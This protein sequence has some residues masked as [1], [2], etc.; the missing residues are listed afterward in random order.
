MPLLWRYWT[1]KFSIVG[2]ILLSGLYVPIQVQAADY[3]TR[4]QA[5]ATLN[6]QHLKQ[7]GSSGNCIDTLLDLANLEL[8][9]RYDQLMNRYQQPVAGSRT[10]TDAVDQQLLSAQYQWLQFRNQQCLFEAQASML[11]TTKATASVKPA[12][13]PNN[14]QTNLQNS[15]QNSNQVKLCQLALTRERIE[16]LQWFLGR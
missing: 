11:T 12:N 2:L 5:Y 1:K 15:Q 3:F 6:C 9:Q 16:Y 8:N 7:N 14:Q 13:P 4:H 10:R